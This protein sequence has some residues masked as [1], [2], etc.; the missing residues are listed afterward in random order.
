M[1]PRAAAGRQLAQ[2]PAPPPPPPAAAL[3]SQ[4]PP[5]NTPGTSIQPWL[6]L[7]IH[8]QLSLHVTKLPDRFGA[9]L[10]PLRATWPSAVIAGPLRTCW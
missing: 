4:R 10:T 9:F 2:Q 3:L 6:H 7:L 1:P 5:Q 8:C